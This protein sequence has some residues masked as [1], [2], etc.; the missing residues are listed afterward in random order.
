MNTQS[1]PAKGKFFNARLT[2]VISISLVL[3]VLGIIAF[4]G[5][6]ANQL[7]TF[8]KENVGFTIVLKDEATGQ[9]VAALRN[10]IEKGGYSRSFVYISKEDALKELTEELGESPAEFLGYNP[11][12]SSVE[13]KL[14]ANYANNDS[15][16]MIEN[17]VRKV[18]PKQVSAFNYRKDIVKLIN[19]NV[20]KMSLALLA[21]AVILLVISFTLINNTVRLSIYSKR[22]LIHTMK[23]VGATPGFIRRPFVTENIVNG[24]I[25]SFVAMLFLGLLILKAMTEFPGFDKIVTTEMLTVVCA[26]ILCLG[27]FITAL[28]SLFA[29]N[30]YIGMR[31][32]DMYLV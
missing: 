15:I 32:D 11:L 5:V 17:A 26:I 13:V 8:V 21:L 4:M 29:T 30:R 24:I 22:F 20:R 10:L 6:F 12:Q 3:F 18:L 23:L 27:I 2:S 25:A 28:A 7:S 9:D 1:Q 16:A 31:G 19:D 14:Y